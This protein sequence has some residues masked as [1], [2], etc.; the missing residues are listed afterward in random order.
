MAGKNDARN[1]VSLKHHGTSFREITLVA[2][3]ELPTR[4]G[5][6]TIMGFLSERDEKEYTVAIHG[7]V[8]GKEDCPV[9]IH[10]ECHTGEIWGCLRCDC[11]EQLEA[12]IKYIT[13]QQYGMVIYCKQ[14]GRGIGLLNKLKAY[15]LQDNGMDTV[16]A[17]LHLG[18]PVDMRDYTVSTDIIQFL[19]IKSVALLTNN[20]K[21][22]EAFQQRGIPVTRRIPLVVNPN[23]YNERYLKTKKEKLHHL[24]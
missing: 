19:D 12:S 14:E 8:T 17:N 2:Q 4:Y 18:F 3:A 7:G 24:L 23:R 10:S 11:R 22:I 6:F 15:H 20:P 5:I 21:K 9:R 1:T 16:E 13:E